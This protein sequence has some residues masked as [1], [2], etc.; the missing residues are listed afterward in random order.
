M[1]PHNTDMKGSI[2]TLIT[3][4][5]GGSSRIRT[6]EGFNTS[7]VFKT[8]SSTNRATSLIILIYFL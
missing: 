6:Y 4:K 7:A 1:K 8:V 5:N 3:P 2:I